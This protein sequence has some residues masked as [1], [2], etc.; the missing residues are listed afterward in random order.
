MTSDDGTAAT[1]LCIEPFVKISQE[2]VTVCDNYTLS[3]T[4]SLSPHSSWSAVLTFLSGEGDD[5]KLTQVMDEIVSI[6]TGAGRELEVKVD[7]KEITRYGRGNCATVH[8][9]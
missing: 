1:L 9:L 7:V 4:L 3:H 8:G 2:S 6:L 5:L